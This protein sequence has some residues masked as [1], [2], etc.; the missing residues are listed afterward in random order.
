LEIVNNKNI[1]LHTA[2]VNEA[3]SLFKYQSV[4]NK[5]YNQ[6]LNLLNIDLNTVNTLEAIPF[7]PIQF[8][9]THQVVSG[10]FTHQTIYTSSSTTGH[11]DSK[12]YIKSVSKYLNNAENIFES[13]YGKL[14]QFCF[15]ALLPNYLERQGSSLIAMINHFMI[16]SPNYKHGFFLNQFELLKEKLIENE[17]LGIKTILFG[18]TY[19]LLDFAAYFNLPLKHTIIIETGGMKGKRKETTKSNVHSVLKNAFLIPTIHSEYGMTELLSQAYSTGNGL[20]LSNQ[21]LQPLI[22]NIY[23]PFEIQNCGQGLLN[24]IDLANEDS[25]SFIATDDLGLIH[26][27]G[28]FEILGRLDAAEIRGCNLLVDN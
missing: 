21:K 2:F 19:A 1:N 8:F 17:N 26:Q 27:N 4:A 28:S 12:H 24:I 10:V 25:C 22:R 6:Y 5:V 18:V 11:G 13:Q 3:L 7:L 23:N 14:N 15:L 20:F 16:K 9:K